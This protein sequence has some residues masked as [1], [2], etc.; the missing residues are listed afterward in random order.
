MFNEEKGFP[1]SVPH[2]PYPAAWPGIRGWKLLKSYLCSRIS[3]LGEDIGVATTL[4]K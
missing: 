4:V 2:L 1:K 3:L